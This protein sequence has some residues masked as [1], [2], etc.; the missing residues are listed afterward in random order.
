MWILSSGRRPARRLRVA[1]TGP[2]LHRSGDP[3]VRLTIAPSGCC[4]RKGRFTGTAFTARLLDETSV[5][6]PDLHPPALQPPVPAHSRPHSDR[7][8][9]APG[10]PSNVG[11]LAV[12]IG[13][14]SRSAV[15]DARRTGSV[16]CRG[17]P[18]SRPAGR[19][20]HVGLCH[21]LMACRI[22]DTCSMAYWT[23]FKRVVWLANM[24]DRRP[25]K[26]PIATTSS[27]AGSGVVAVSR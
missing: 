26:S 9:R 22:F 16:R 20:P 24:A 23:R 1:S 14:L 25:S 12:S 13:R 8:A 2:K 19:G 7:V 4:V 21:Q 18:V 6:D 3:E 10:R 5:T 17:S 15:R 27:T 11:V